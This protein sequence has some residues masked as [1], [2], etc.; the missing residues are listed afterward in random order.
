MILTH[1][2]YV[3]SVIIHFGLD[4]KGITELFL[5]LYVFSVLQQLLLDD[6]RILILV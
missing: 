3:R 1:D 5:E 6:L 2:A 4:L